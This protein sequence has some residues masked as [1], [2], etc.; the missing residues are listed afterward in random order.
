MKKAIDGKYQANKYRK[1]S[2]WEASVMIGESFGP[3]L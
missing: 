2:E 3:Q 1:P